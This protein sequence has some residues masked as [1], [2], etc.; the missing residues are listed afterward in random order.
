MTTSFVQNTSQSKEQAHKK[1]G[2]SSSDLGTDFRQTWDTFKP[3]FIFSW[4]MRYLS[5]TVLKSD[6]ICAY[7][8][9][10]VQ[11]V[12]IGIRAVENVADI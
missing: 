6:A 7:I 3:L 2:I 11:Y 9:M 4:F 10:S 8:D 12:A 1:Y 5:G